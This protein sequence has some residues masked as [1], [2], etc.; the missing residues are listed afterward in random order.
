M[1]LMVAVWMEVDVLIELGGRDNTVLGGVF[2]T[3]HVSNFVNQQSETTL[4]VFSSKMNSWTQFNIAAGCP[5]M[6]AVAQ[7][8][9]FGYFTCNYRHSLSSRPTAGRR[10]ANALT[11]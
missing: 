2:E 11:L 5:K 10:S 8:T 9:R 6:V 4:W 1:V 7:V 3:G